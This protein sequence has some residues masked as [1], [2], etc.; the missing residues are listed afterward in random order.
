MKD[1]IKEGSIIAFAV[2]GILVL[3]YGLS[4]LIT[5]GLIKLITMCFGWEFEWSTATGIWLIICILSLTFKSK[6]NTKK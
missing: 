3:S 4:W 2:F 1:K 5:C 6:V